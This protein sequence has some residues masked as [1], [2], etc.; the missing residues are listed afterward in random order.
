MSLRLIILCVNTD[1]TYTYMGIVQAWAPMINPHI[2]SIGEY[3]WYNLAIPQK[4]YIYMVDALF[5][6]AV[7]ISLVLYLP[8]IYVRK[9]VSLYIFAGQSQS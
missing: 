9:K 3:W 5:T 4:A 2:N 8:K 7:L 6:Y 1:P